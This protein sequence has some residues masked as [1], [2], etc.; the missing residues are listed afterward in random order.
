MKDMTRG[1]PF[2]NILAFSLPMLLGNVF[3]QVYNDLTNPL[4]FINSKAN[5]TV[6]IG[7]ASFRGMYATRYDLLMAASVFTLAPILVLFVAAQKYFVEGVVMT[8]LKG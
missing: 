8:G 4:I 7:L 6:Q 1:S 2:G 3:Q 5:F